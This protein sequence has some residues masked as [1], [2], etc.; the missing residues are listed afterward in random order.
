MWERTRVYTKLMIIWTFEAATG[1]DEYLSKTRWKTKI[2]SFFE[3]IRVKNT[4]S[5]YRK[6]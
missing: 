4:N 3:I 1:S 5:D 2:G 6:I